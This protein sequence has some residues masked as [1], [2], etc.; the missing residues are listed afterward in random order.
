MSDQF[1]MDIHTDP[2]GRVLLKIH[3]LTTEITDSLS[4]GDG[5]YTPFYEGYTAF[6]TSKNSVRVY[7]VL[8]KGKRLLLYS[9][10]V[11]AVPKRIMYSRTEST[12]F[13][14]EVSVFCCIKVLMDHPDDIGH[15]LANE[16]DNEIRR[17]DKISPKSGETSEEFVQSNALW[18]A[19]PV[20]N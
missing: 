16:N 4:Y 13:R 19:D 2:R 12:M 6:E 18:L 3:D 1:T 10:E 5:A 11:P 9:V 15:I 8:A 7:L 17:R 20:I 14:K